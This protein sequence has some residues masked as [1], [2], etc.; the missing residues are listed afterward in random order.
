MS[1]RRHEDY[2][3]TVQ[4]LYCR[5]APQNAALCRNITFQVTS[6]CN[7]RCSYCYEHH[8]TAERMSF[9]TGKAIVDYILDLYE[10]GESDF[11]NRTTRAVILDFIGGE[12]LLEAELI[13]R[14]C[15][16]WF[17]ECYRRNIPLAPF[18]R[19]SFATN[20]K[21]WFSPAAQHLFEKYH[22]LMSVTVS[23]DGVQE[24]HDLYR[25]DEHGAGSFCD[26]WKAFQDGKK[27]Y[28]WLGSKMTFVPGSFRYISASLIMMLKEGCTEIACNYAYEPEYTPEDGRVL[29]EQ[30]RKVSDYIIG[31]TLDVSV[32]ILD[33]LLGGP[34]KDDKNYCGGTGA[35]LSFAP[36]GS[37]YPCIRY[38]PISIGTEKAGRVC[39]G[40]IHD[41]LYKTA[42]QKRVKKDL[43]SI[44]RT[45]QSPQK[46]LDCP[47]SAGC[48]W[49]SG[50]NYELY[51]T[52]NRRATSICW[53]HKARVLASSYYFNRRYLSIGDC[54]PVCDRLSDDDAL[55]ILPMADLSEL[56]SI[57]R[58]ALEKFAEE[59]DERR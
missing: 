22:E 50:W 25:V 43:D 57:E 2:G 8:K 19:I 4:R 29:Y 23:I 32:T 5:D 37:A 56:R 13:E 58:K 34:E 3:N 48:G 46:C 53:A 20:G 12:P 10:N 41:G 40:N 52:A 33:S 15:D 55:R 24:L 54:L 39:L 51:G 21:L 14:I 16:Y 17:A 11:V 42:Q 31:Q 47:V 18:T 30:L 6:G 1:R 28:G 7:L 36:D 9:E 27:K 38:A 59:L 45:S 35:M 26:A 49:C 44:T